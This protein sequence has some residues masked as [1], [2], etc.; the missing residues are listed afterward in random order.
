[1]INQSIIVN[2]VLILTILYLANKLS[3][4]KLLDYIK[5]I[6]YLNQFCK[7]EEKQINNEE[8]QLTKYFK[9]LITKKP[10]HISNTYNFSKAY[11]LNNEDALTVIKYLEKKFSQSKNILIKNMKLNNKLVYSKNRNVFEISPFLIIGEYYNN[12]KYEG[13]IKLQIELSFRFDKSSS[14]FMSPLKINKKTGSFDINRIFLINLSKNLSITKK[15]KIKPIIVDTK[16]DSDS[17]DS[18]IPSQIQ[19]SN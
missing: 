18:L 15:K 17:I 12:S 19:L 10:L 16:Q 3:N 7:K 8:Q 13:I 9:S 2:L 6:S 1:M 5:N 14:I 11:L 4:N